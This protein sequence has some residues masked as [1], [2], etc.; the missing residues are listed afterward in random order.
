MATE[1]AA[2][3]PLLA[4]RFY[5]PP[6]A[7]HRVT[8]QRLLGYL[9]HCLQVPVT[10]ISAPAG[11]GKSTLLSE[12]IQTQP[13]LQT[14]WLSLEVEDNEWPRF[15]HYLITALQKF[16]PK[17]GESALN[18]MGASQA[19][20]ELSVTW[21][22]N[23]LTT[24]LSGLESSTPALLVLDDLHHINSSK[25][26]AGLTFLCEHLPPQIH[27]AIATR[28]DPPL[29]LPR[30]RSRSQLLELR[31][32]HLRF[33]VDEAAAFL[34]AATDMNLT[35]EIV[36]RLDERTEGWIVG[37]QMAA[38]S[39]RG[40]P[41]PEAFVRAFSGS[42]RYV[43]DY[44][45]EEVLQRQ[46]EL[47]QR[48]LLQTS[49]L[50]R[51][52]ASLCAAVLE[53][54]T[55]DT[56]QAMLERLERDNLFIIP[57]DDDRCYYRYHHLF[58]DLLRVKLAQNCS[59]DISTLHRRAANWYADQTLWKNAIRH[60]FLANDPEYAADLFERGVL[61]QRLDFLFSDITSLVQQFPE[62]LIQR[63][64]L[65]ALGKTAS[66]IQQSQLDGITSL[67]RAVEQ[68]VREDKS[69][70]GWQSMLGTVYIVQSAAASL[71]GD[72]SWMSESS[73]QAMALF[74][75]SDNDHVTAVAQLGNVYYF[76]GEFHK[77]DAVLVRGME[78]SRRLGNVYR[79]LHY[80][81]ALAR[82]RHQKGEL[83]SAETLFQDALHLA[84][85]HGG[86]Y[87]RWIGAIQHDYGDLLREHNLLDDARQLVISG[88]EV[89]REREWIGSQ[90][91]AYIHLG[92]VL[93]TLGDLS[94]ADDALRQAKGLAATYT[95]YPDL[96]VMMRV[97]E[98]HLL[99][100]SYAS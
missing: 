79:T 17:A 37:L 6:L 72:I 100:G 29:P 69:F 14:S 67:L 53:S 25:I 23:D 46:P 96:L 64:P 39:M 34:R 41:D 70:E 5:P 99:L 78:I 27:L 58:A 4:T 85:Q 45:V 21:L 77:V 7:A 9:D 19:A 40:R 75:E 90:G 32:D 66:M 59:N 44:L 49:L 71:L 82:L 74:Q 12:W 87:R 54:E 16:C 81:D 91:L 38:L 13:S 68:G 11:F 47:V 86:R 22:L 10:L 51:M 28:S 52:N 42:H 65:L 84:S 8:R 60:A 89:C 26:H 93:L 43:L 63:R 88:L 3:A 15:F 98:S 48:F 36:A 2:S 35:T 20:P 61:L 92:N 1:S 18:E 62:A 97:F 57:L 56:A 94:G 24:S 30:W 76:L 83:Q 55:I 50:E 80:M 33:T 73:Q 31:S 95:V